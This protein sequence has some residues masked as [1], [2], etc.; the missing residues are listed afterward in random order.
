MSQ[1]AVCCALM[2]YSVL[3]AVDPL[4]RLLKYSQ[5]GAENIANRITSDLYCRSNSSEMT[6]ST[7][8]PLD[9]VLLITHSSVLTCCSAPIHQMCAMALLHALMA[10]MRI[11]SCVP[12][13]M[14]DHLHR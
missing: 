1:P 12:N 11:R 7:L 5:T 3:S 4:I 8:Q 6:T 13:S 2:V 10:Q 9:G 14:I